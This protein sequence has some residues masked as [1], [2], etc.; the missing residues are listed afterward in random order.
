MLVHPNTLRILGVQQ[1]FAPENTA[2]KAH[3]LKRILP[4][5]P[6]LDCFIHDRAC[7]F[8]VYGRKDPALAQIKMYCVD[9]CHG[10]LHNEKCGYSPQTN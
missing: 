4:L 10:R 2:V 1:M 8:Q 5:Y 3:S 7:D 9:W 6:N